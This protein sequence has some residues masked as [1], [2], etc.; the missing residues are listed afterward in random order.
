MD[1]ADQFLENGNMAA[2]ESG[3]GGFKKS[4]AASL[5]ES[6]ISSDASSVPPQ[7]PSDNA[8]ESREGKSLLSSG[9]MNSL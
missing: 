9:I 3:A 5:R 7:Y 1:S 2:F 8:F 6:N 4:K